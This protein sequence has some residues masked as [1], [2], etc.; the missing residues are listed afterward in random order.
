MCRNG[1]SWIYELE[2]DFEWESHHGLD[3]EF[4]FVDKDGAVRLILGRGGRI[5]VTRGY[6][7]DGCSPKL[8]LWDILIGTPDGVVHVHTGKPKTYYASL[9]HDAL[10][11]FLPDGLPFRRSEIDSFFLRLLAESDFRPRFIYWTAVRVF[12]GLSRR[13]TRLKRGYRGRRL[14]A[15][16]VPSATEGR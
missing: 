2:R 1:V 5:T 16:E 10:Y 11:Q 7:W 15:P 3:E 14:H 8:C 6:S 12:G 13:V 9:V 4:V